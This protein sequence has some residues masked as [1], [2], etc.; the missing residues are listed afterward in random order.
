MRGK[1]LLSGVVGL[2]TLAGGWQAAL[3][4][5]RG[6]GGTGFGTS[7]S[8]MSRQS[9]VSSGQSVSG[10][11]RQG[12]FGSRTTGGSIG[13][14]ARSFGG[15]QS[16]IGSGMGAASGELS[17]NERFMRGNRQ[18]GQFVGTD[19]G[20]IGNFIGA[21][22]GA[23]SQFGSSGSRRNRGSGQNRNQSDYNG[24]NREGRDGGGA[25]SAQRTT[26]PRR[27]I[28]AFDQPRPAPSRVS[29]ALQRRLT[30]LEPLSSVA[31][32]IEG[33]QAVL[34]GLVATAHDRDLAEQLIRL[35]P[36][37]DAVQNE[38]TLGPISPPAASSP[39]GSRRADS[40]RT[41]RPAPVVSGPNSIR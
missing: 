22:Q 2:A 17:G 8:G 16:G 13:A 39:A 19:V 32:T 24:R 30:R 34:R 21:M 15:A 4:Q 41:G 7:G 33:H 1:W 28:V 36:G 9:G 14:R 11:S 29:A 31:V 26:M 35:E 23:D 3:A 12:M 10:G 18:P 6:G 38:L 20:D 25:R 5:G 37:I 40:A 27:V